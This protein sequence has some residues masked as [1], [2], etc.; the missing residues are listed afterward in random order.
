MQRSNVESS[1]WCPFIGWKSHS[2]QGTHVRKEVY[3]I[4]PYEVG[5][6]MYAVVGWR[7]CYLYSLA[8]NNIG[9]KTGIN[10][11]EQYVTIFWEL[12]SAFSR[13]MN[14]K[15]LKKNSVFAL[16][17][18]QTTHATN[19]AHRPEGPLVVVDNFYTRHVLAEQIRQVSNGEVSGLG[20]TRITNFDVP[21]KVHVR[22]TIRRLGKASRDSWF[23]CRAF[24]NRLIRQVEQE[25]V[26]AER[27]GFIVWKNRSFVT[28]YCN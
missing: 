6:R 20:N 5:I 23:L 19:R 24:H 22:D 10:Q 18:L 14:N 26:V 28:F 7:S 15:L 11:V 21:N 4:Q 1:E 9:T 12:R 8:D 3:E 2:L 16:W 13:K 25:V 27:L 17:A